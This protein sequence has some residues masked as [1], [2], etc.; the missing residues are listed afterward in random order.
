[1]DKKWLFKSI[2]LNSLWIIWI[3]L[4]VLF[5]YL[6]AKNC[7]PE[8]LALFIPFSLAFLAAGGGAAF[9]V[10]RISSARKRSANKNVH[11]D[12]DAT[13]AGDDVNNNEN[14]DEQ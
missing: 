3:A 7:F 5:G 6:I 14:R 8:N 2:L 13:A 11:A 1:M 4:S 10:Y 12:G 9:A